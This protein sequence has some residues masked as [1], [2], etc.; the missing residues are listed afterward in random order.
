ALK[1]VQ[2]AAS[3]SEHAL[4]C[5][6]AALD[7]SDAKAE[8][9]EDVECLLKFNR[10]LSSPPSTKAFVSDVRVAGFFEDWRVVEMVSSSNFPSSI[11]R[12]NLPI[13]ALACQ[14]I[15]GSATTSDSVTSFARAG[16]LD[17]VLN[18]MDSHKSHGGVQNVALFLL[19]TLLKD[20]GAAR[21]AVQNG[22][23][24]RVLHALNLSMGREIQRLHSDERVWGSG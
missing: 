19:R 12:E 15:A 17:E 21:Q 8:D 16:V 11:V 1:G 2:E 3:L 13:V 23:I 4:R 22:A 14:C 10:L 18:V 6:I 9:I 20:S 7:H 5:T 24:A